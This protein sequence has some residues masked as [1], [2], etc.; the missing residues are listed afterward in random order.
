MKCK[1]QL[2]K[3]GHIFE[4]IVYAKDYQDAKATALARNPGAKITWVTAVFD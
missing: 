2:Y 1:V 3:A 4:E